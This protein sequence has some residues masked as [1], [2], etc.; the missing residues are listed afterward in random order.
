[1]NKQ[2]IRNLFT[3][4]VAELLAQGYTIHPDTMPGSQGEIAH[5]DLDNGS[6]ILRVL[7]NRDV[8]YS[9][10][11]YGNTIRLTVGKATVSYRGHWDELIW[12][13]ELEKRFE[14]ELAEIGRDFYT[15]LTTAAEIHAKRRA[16]WN[17][18][19]SS[20]KRDTTREELGTAY[21]SIALR[22]LQ[23]QPRMK[24]AKLTD[25]DRMERVTT[26]TG[27]RSFEIRARGTTFTLKP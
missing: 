4:K 23:K 22:W 15:D 20:A 21:K 26:H 24:S 16:R 11:F 3:Q 25:I 7:L 27:K 9:D 13:Q 2:D 5:I 17:A 12:N 1:M 19:P 14:I 18:K 8:H 6:E 10:D